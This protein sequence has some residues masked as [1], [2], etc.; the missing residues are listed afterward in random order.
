M[1]S[2]KTASSGVPLYSNFGT[3]TMHSIFTKKAN[4]AT[5]PPESNEYSATAAQRNNGPPY[6]DARRKRAR[7]SA[8]VQT[9][10]DFLGEGKWAS[11]PARREQINKA[12]EFIEQRRATEYGF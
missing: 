9:P 11:W 4:A 5:N 7:H 6:T 12:R 1:G 10:R 3:N 8:V 2:I